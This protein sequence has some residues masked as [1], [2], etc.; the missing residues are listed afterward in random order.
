MAVRAQNALV[1]LI[2]PV[3][4]GLGYELVGIEY[5]PQGKHSLIRIYVDSEQ[6]IQ[7]EDCEK[8]SR[9]ISAVLDVEDP[10][11]GQYVM[12]VSSPGLDRPLF[13]P[14]HYLRFLGHRAKLRLR[15]PL[16]GQRKFRGELLSADETH[17]VLQDVDTGQEFKLTLADI[18]KAN[19]EPEFD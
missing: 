9:Q 14:E 1:A 16:N 12:E 2:E 3:V 8:V 6:G 4:T 18:E 7:L 15:Q 19:L 10:I 11:T 17:V 13:K 5:L